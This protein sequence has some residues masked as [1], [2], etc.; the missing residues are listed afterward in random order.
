MIAHLVRD[1]AP[2]P[3]RSEMLA[4][5]TAEICWWVEVPLFSFPNPTPLHARASAHCQEIHV[6][7]YLA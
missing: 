5:S 3:Q 4:Q 2:P 7:D 6:E 1:S